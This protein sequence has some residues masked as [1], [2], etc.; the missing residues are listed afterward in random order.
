MSFVVAVCHE[1]AAVGYGLA[2]WLG[3]CQ[4]RF[5][6]DQKVIGCGHL[7]PVQHQVLGFMHAWAL[8]AQLLSGLFGVSSSVQKDILCFAAIFEAALQV[9]GCLTG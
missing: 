9:Y 7:A 1:H 4:D 3:S 5:E 8:L 2:L 6:W